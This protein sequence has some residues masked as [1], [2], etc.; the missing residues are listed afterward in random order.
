[1]ELLALDDT[2]T[3]TPAIP[4]SRSSLSVHRRSLLFLVLD[5]VIA[6]AAP[7]TGHHPGML[8]RRYTHANVPGLIHPNGAVRRLGDVSNGVPCA[9]IFGDA[10]AHRKHA[11]RAFRKISFATA[12][13]C[14]LVQNSGIAVRVLGVE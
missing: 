8:R 14:Q 10:A 13:I 5:F 3:A 9:Y 2:Q 4:A 11:G 6:M 7:R 12:D 1:M